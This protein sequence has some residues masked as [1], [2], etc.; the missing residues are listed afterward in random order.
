MEKI[1]VL[2]HIFLMI[3]SNSTCELAISPGKLVILT[4]I[5]FDCLAFDS[6][7]TT[8]IIKPSNLI[9]YQSAAS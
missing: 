9:S 4:K 7:E 6:K 5:A 2:A 8:T 3:I 1:V